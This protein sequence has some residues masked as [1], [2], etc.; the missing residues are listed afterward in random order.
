MVCATLLDPNQPNHH[1]TASPVRARERQICAPEKCILG[2]LS[3]GSHP[4]YV[5]VYPYNRY[6]RSTNPVVRHAVSLT[7]TLKRM[8]AYQH[9]PKHA[10][11]QPLHWPKHARPG[12]KSRGT[13]RALRRSSYSDHCTGSRY[14]GH[15]EGT[16][17]CVLCS[18]TFAWALIIMYVNLHNLR[19]AT[20]LIP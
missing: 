10:A 7:C 12:T 8:C 4:A 15:I 14:N 13:I 5:T 9:V 1:L 2:R 18:Y 6:I 11:T 20:Q 16:N 17:M 19:K 3:R